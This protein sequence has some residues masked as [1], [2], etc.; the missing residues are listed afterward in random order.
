MLILLAGLLLIFSG[1][2]IYFNYS[3]TEKKVYNYKKIDSLF[4]KFDALNKKQKLEKTIDSKLELLDFSDCDIKSKVVKKKD[5]SNLKINI[6]TATL[7]EFIQLPGIG[8]K[9]AA[10]I[11]D[12]RV[13]RKRF[14]SID[15]L[16]D[17][18][19]IGKKKF[20]KIKNYIIIK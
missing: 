5:I 17:V 19:G 11:L 6:N 9:T 12:L 20:E 8:N 10:A 1:L 3:E 7:N 14:V 16:M 18:K 4:T 2:R 15:E 13:K